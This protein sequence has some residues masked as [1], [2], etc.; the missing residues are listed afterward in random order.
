MSADSVRSD[1]AHPLL[2]LLSMRDNPQL[3]PSAIAA[4]DTCSLLLPTFLLVAAG[5]HVVS[6]SLND[7]YR[8]T[9]CYLSF[10][11]KGH[12][13]YSCLGSDYRRAIEFPARVDQLPPT[14]LL[15]DRAFRGVYVGVT[16][17]PFSPWSRI[18]NDLCRLL[19]LGNLPGQLEMSALPPALFPGLF[20]SQS[21]WR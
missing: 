13:Q 6:L 4:R 7:V 19:L 12:W 11:L 8:P 3:L 5:S 16:V 18:R 14:A 1:T 10:D 17:F 20:H 9:G 15:R 21:F 2:S